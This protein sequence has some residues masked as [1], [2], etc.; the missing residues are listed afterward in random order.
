MGLELLAAAGVET[1]L[2]GVT[3]SGIQTAAT[4]GGVA[5][6]AGGL[7]TSVYGQTQQAE[8]SK[9][10]EGL[11]KQQ[12]E[13]NNQRE[14]RQIFRQAQNAR[15]VAL[16]N[17]T[18]SGGEKSSG[19]AG[20]YGQIASASGA[21]S[22]AARENL[23]IGEGLFDA[24]K[25]LSEAKSITAI[26]SGVSAFGKDLINVGPELGRIGTT[27]FGG[28]KRAGD[29]PRDSGEEISGYDMFQGLA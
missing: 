7:A 5:L 15:A 2:A 13:L 27:Y 9:K 26:G 22:V 14:Q 3:A 23:N 20:G 29:F 6:G 1:L 16:S 21:N 8:A 12:M 10:A 18:A 19:L 4:V 25:Q 11:R 28:R 17:A 24:N